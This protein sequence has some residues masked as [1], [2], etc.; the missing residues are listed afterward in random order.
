MPIPAALPAVR[1]ERGNLHWASGLPPVPS[2][3]VP[4]EFEIHVRELELT[5]EMYAGSRELK[6]WCERNRNRV[7]IPEWLL[8]KLLK[9]PLMATQCRYLGNDRQLRPRT[10]SPLRSTV[11]STT[12]PML[13]RATRKAIPYRSWAFALS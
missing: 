5:P 6:N 10:S 13:D 7:Y 9:E 1:H 2:P 4:A 11:A 3:A 12:D 8:K